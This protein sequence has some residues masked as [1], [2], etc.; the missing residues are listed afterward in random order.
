[1]TR[2]VNSYLIFFKT[3]QHGE[4]CQWFHECWRV[5]ATRNINDRLCFFQYGTLHRLI[6]PMMENMIH[7]ATTCLTALT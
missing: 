6:K 1:M 5:P 3:I 4:S 7:E 2:N